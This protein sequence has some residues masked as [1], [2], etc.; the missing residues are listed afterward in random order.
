MILSSRQLTFSKPYIPK[1]SP[2]FVFLLYSDI[3]YHLRDHK[4]Q[5]SVFMK[6]WMCLIEEMILKNSHSFIFEI[7]AYHIDIL[8][9]DGIRVQLKLCKK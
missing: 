4:V 2:S 3:Y 5:L 7:W 9:L 8:S 1:S 6:I